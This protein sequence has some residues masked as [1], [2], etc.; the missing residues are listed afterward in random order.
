M[1]AVRLWLCGLG[2]LAGAARAQR[3]EF[4]WPTP[5]RAF[6]EGRPIAAY[7]QQAGSGDPASGGFGCVRSD[8]R[9]FHEGI[10]VQPVSR[11]RRGEPD[12][13]VFAAMD[14]VVRYVNL[15]PGNSSYGRYVVLEHPGVQPAI[16]T[17]YAHL[18]RVAPEIRPGAAVRRGETLGRMGH[19]AGGYTIPKD[20]AHLHFEMGVMLSQ[21]FQAWYDGKRFGSRNEH[22]LYNGYNLMGFDPLAFLRDYRDHRLDNFQQFFDHMA[23]A[24]TVRIATT[25]VPDFVRRY[26]SLVVKRA[27]GLI[28]GWE[29]SVDWTGLPFRWVPLSADEVRGWRRDEVRVISVDNATERRYQCKSVAVLRRGQ[30]IPG[31]SLDETLQIV[32]GR[33]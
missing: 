31:A 32:F 8:G 6:D 26:P 5:N 7:L 18:E 33:R 22:G 17:L 24:A 19:S 13:P 30:W 2:L 23:P 10:D 12:D 11:D 27:V 21:N 4:A 3:V 1:K 29:V 20:R 28:A 14:G 9:Q 16:Y 15:T 25:Q